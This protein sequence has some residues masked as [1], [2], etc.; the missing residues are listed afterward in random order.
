MKSKPGYFTPG[1]AWVA[2]SDVSAW[3][4]KW[5]GALSD[6]SISRPSIES[7]VLKAG[8]FS[9]VLVVPMRS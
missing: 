9:S 8:M 7:C 3:L 6:D 1:T 2:V 5:K 4:M